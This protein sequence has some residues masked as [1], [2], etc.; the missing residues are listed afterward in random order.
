M[1]FKGRNAVLEVFHRDDM[2]L[3]LQDEPL[4]SLVAVERSELVA[5]RQSTCGPSLSRAQWPR[6]CFSDHHLGLSL[7]L[8]FRLQEKVFLVND[9]GMLD[10]DLV[11]MLFLFISES[12]YRFSGDY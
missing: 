1:A 4:E 10:F 6:H 11:I 9:R 8:I 5:L 7:L 12:A 2:G 3:G